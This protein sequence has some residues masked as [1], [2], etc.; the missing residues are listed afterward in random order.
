MFVCCFIF[1]AVVRKRKWTQDSLDICVLLLL[2][3]SRGRTRLL[4]CKDM[5]VCL[6]VCFAAAVKG[7]LGECQLDGCYLLKYGWVGH[8]LNHFSKMPL[9]WY[10][11]LEWVQFAGRFSIIKGEYLGSNEGSLELS[12]VVCSLADVWLSKLGNINANSTM[13]A[14]MHSLCKETSARKQ[15]SCNPTAVWA[16]LAACVLPDAVQVA[17]C[18]L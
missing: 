16:A 12:V 8:F 1:K 13:S 9:S 2:H 3:W 18:H 5:Y 17:G 10:V 14:L 7:E 15:P 6:C 4:L 11:C